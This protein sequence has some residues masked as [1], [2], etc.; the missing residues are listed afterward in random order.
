[1]VEPEAASKKTSCACERQSE[2]A[3]SSRAFV[4]AFE[5]SSSEEEDDDEEEVV[6]YRRR[7]RGM[8]CLLRRCCCSS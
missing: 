8:A 3:R 4:S 6:E 1:M 7:A 5:F 2:P